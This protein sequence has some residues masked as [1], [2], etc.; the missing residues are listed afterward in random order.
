[1]PCCPSNYEMSWADSGALGGGYNNHIIAE[2]RSHVT[3][4]GTLQGPARGQMS[5]LCRGGATPRP[6][7]ARRSRILN[8]R[9]RHRRN[10][11]RISCLS[12]H[13]L[14]RRIR[15][16]RTQNRSRNPSSPGRPRS[17]STCNAASRRPTA[18]PT[19]A[20]PTQ[21]KP[22]APSSATSATA[23]LWRS[24]PEFQPIGGGL[25]LFIALGGQYLCQETQRYG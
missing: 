17:A 19:E 5:H 7:R 6:A 10:R 8:R 9:S 12:K 22:A 20:T 24:A 16:L 14:S 1:M 23:S 2:V 13:T 25:D 15:H 4:K 18:C 11:S 21:P 3:R